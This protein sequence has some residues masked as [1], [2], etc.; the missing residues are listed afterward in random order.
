MAQWGVKISII[1]QEKHKHKNGTA[2]IDL[3]EKHIDCETYQV[4]PA[5]K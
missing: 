3:C 5:Y 1:S 2:I 4:T